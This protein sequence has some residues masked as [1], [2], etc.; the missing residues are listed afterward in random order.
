MI[1]IKGLYLHIPFCKRKC[2]YCSFY[3]IDKYDRELTRV[4]ARALIREF[5]QRRHLLS[6]PYTLY[7]G[8]GTPLILGIENL[9]RVIRTVID[10]LGIPL[11]FTIEL[12]PAVI[13]GYTFKMLKEWNVT[14]ISIGVQS[15]SDRVLKVLGRIHSAS[16]AR[17]SL[18]EAFSIFENVNGDFI[19]GVPGQDLRELEY[20]L[21]QISKFPFTHISYYSLTLEEGTPLYIEVLQGKLKE[22]RESLWVEM[23]NMVHRFLESHGFEHYEISNFA[24]PGSRCLHNLAYWRRR[25]YVGLGAS[26]SSFFKNVREQNVA[27]VI[28]YVMFAEEGRFR[29][30]RE[31]IDEVKEVEEVIMLGLRTKAGFSLRK[32]NP[33]FRQM[34]RNRAVEL[35]REGLVELKGQWICVPFSRWSV[36]DSIITRLIP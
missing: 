10:T 16:V 32:L 25:E 6:A 9:E 36:L 14:R 26:A 20:D 5:E 7:V 21:T 19:F 28:R 15:F 34:V 2:A 35:S 12:N 17:R 1:R 11:E 4:Y 33:K 31:V 18:E 8:G 27:D 13:G 29:R 30:E 22:V 3:S 23:F 24:K